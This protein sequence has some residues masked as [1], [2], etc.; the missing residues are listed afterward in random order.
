M[1]RSPLLLLLILGAIA[2]K[3][4]G[5]QSTTASQPNIRYHLGDNLAWAEPHFDDSAW[6]M[7]TAGQFS[8]PDYHSDGFVWIRSQIAVPSGADPLA[9]EWQTFDAAPHVQEM[10]V[11]GRLVGGYGDFPPHAR[12]LVSPK[13]LVFDIPAD[14]VQPGS[15]AVIALRT[16]NA[17]DDRSESLLRRQ[18]NPINVTFSIGAGPLLHTLVAQAQD[19]AWLRYWPKVT[20][21]LV[22]IMMGL[23]VLALGIWARER[24]LLLCALWLVALPA[25]F[26]VAPLQSLLAGAP[27]STVY[28][29]FLIFNAF[30]MYVVVEFTW[31]VQGFR[32]RIFRVVWHICWIGLTAGFICA[33]TVM[34][35]GKLVSAGVL[36]GNWLLFAFNG[37]ETGANL[38]ALTGRGRNRAVAVAMILIS[39]GYFL[40]L[41][42]T[43]LN[44]QWLGLN[45]FTSS[46]Y[47]CTL[48][49]AV[50]LMRQTWTTW[51]KA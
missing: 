13:I 15:I 35:S 49:I 39:V 5:A 34:H 23:A 37:I 36:T 19:R 21:A 9:I 28:T 22:F 31:A 48:F 16:W 4:G 41:V 30:G 6:P 10:W 47:V 29:V 25:F 51:R 33:A 45:F 44:F 17:P 7:A 12:P 11:N 46:F 38:V 3:T 27:A 14:V 2:P 20:I 8:A 50:L 43:P 24:Q 18:P 32:N 42:G 26:T 1:R 40:G